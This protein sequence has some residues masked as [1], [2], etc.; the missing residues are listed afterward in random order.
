MLSF[1]RRVAKKEIPF[2]FACP[3]LIWQFLFLYLPLFSLIAYSFTQR[4]SIERFFKFT[5]QHYFKIFNSL[6]FKI[7]FNSFLLATTT[8]VICLVIAYPVAYFFSMRV[9]RFKTLLLF[10]LIL[11]SWTSFIVQVYAWFFLLQKRG[12]IS[13][14]LGKLGL[15]APGSHLLNNSFSVL[16]GMTYCFLPFMILPI[17]AVLERI[18]KR[19]LE[20]SADLGANWFHTCKRIIFPLSFPGVAA[21]FMLVFIPAFGEFAVPDLLGGGKNVYWGTIIVEKFLLTRDWQAGSALTVMGIAL[22]LI[23]FSLNYFIYRFLSKLKKRRKLVVN[24]ENIG[25]LG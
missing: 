23:F 11:P 5:L 1:L 15:V 8:A 25:R 13:F 12:I 7:I 2:I 19:L 6:Y 17:Y 24:L 3:A 21:G 4:V 16:V 18:D 14:L 20:A 10:S 9:K 22:L